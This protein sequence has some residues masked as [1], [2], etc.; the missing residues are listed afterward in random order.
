[1][2]TKK[3]VMGQSFEDFT[4]DQKAIHV[5]KAEEKGKV[6]NDNDISYRI[7]RDYLKDFTAVEENLDL[8]PEIKEA[9]SRMFATQRRTS[10][11]GVR[12]TPKAVIGKAILGMLKA[13]PVSEQE[14]FMTSMELGGGWGRAEMKN[15]IKNNIKCGPED[16]VWIT[17]ETT[18]GEPMGIYTVA[19]SGPDAPVDWEGYVPVDTEIDL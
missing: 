1:M 13:G 8:V 19:G 16:R 2:A 12:S 9:L 10:S 18:A 6:P 15:F 7:A 11:G 5:A 4:V 17:L 14:V 3:I